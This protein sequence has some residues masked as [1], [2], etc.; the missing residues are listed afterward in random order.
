MP[1]M[2]T[3]SL[4]KSSTPPPLP[5]AYQ[6]PQLL[7]KPRRCGAGAGIAWIRKAFDMFK[8]NIGV[9]IGMTVAMFAI[10]VV[11]T[12][13]PL[14]GILSGLVVIIFIGSFMQAAAIQERGERLKFE[15]LFSAFS[16]HLKPLL[17]LTLLYMVSI[18]V[19]FILTFWGMHLL[20]VS[21]FLEVWVALDDIGIRSSGQ[22]VVML[23]MLIALLPMILLS[24]AFWFAPALIVLHDMAAMTA[25]K[26]SLQACL[27]NWLA[28][29]VFGVVG[30][31]LS[32][33]L[34]VFTL[35]IGFLLVMP[36]MLLVYYASYRDIWTDQPLSIDS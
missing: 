17:I 29:L 26:K 34:M 13:V 14:F 16:T 1:D 24:M 28:F 23:Y 33:V 32:V 5:P 10:M 35:G 7:P 25:V 27:K 12:I 3:V 30:G 6:D 20:S 9:W 15:Y 4:D 8:Q 18:A 36:M 2:S 19:F 31:L 22:W 11:L 21:N